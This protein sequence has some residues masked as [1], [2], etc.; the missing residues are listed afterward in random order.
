MRIIDCEQGSPEW[1]AARIG[2]ITG[3]EAWKL[4]VKPRNKSDRYSVTT[5]EYIS[6][7][8]G[9]TLT[10][11]YP[12]ISTEATRWGIEQ[13]PNA[14]EAYR[15]KYGPVQRIGA[16]IKSELGDK[17]LCSPD[18]IT[19]QLLIEIK[20]PWL[21]RNHILHL[22]GHIKKEYFAQIQFNMWVTERSQAHF[23]SY[24][25]RFPSNLQLGVHLVELDEKM[26]RQFEAIVPGV[27]EEVDRILFELLEMKND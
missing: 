15:S 3:S 19:E 5:Q 22:Q 26:I 12:S 1:H 18:A 24:D 9:E 16:A 8:I 4:L 6:D 17:V 13:E 10:G 14:L 7:L 20:C 27:L 23:V 2:A 25:P 11:W 21:S